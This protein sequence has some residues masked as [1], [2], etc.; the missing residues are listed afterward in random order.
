[1][2]STIEIQGARSHPNS[3]DEVLKAYTACGGGRIELKPRMGLF[4]QYALFREGSTEQTPESYFGTESIRYEIEE[5]GE[6]AEI[7]A[8]SRMDPR[9]QDA[10]PVDQLVSQRHREILE[11]GGL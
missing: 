7:G 6:L 8:V 3:Y 4:I 10:P 5:P 11:S 9:P 1:L 2:P